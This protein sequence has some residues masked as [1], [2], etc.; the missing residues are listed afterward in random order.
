MKYKRITIKVQKCDG[1]TLWGY[2]YMAYA[3]IARAL[4]LAIQRHWND[5]IMI[6]YNKKIKFAWKM[7]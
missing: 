2:V 7:L 3:F 5:V 6:L 4:Y 1:V